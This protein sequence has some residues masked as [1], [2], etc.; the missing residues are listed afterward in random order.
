[1]YPASPVSTPSSDAPAI[2]VV[3]PTYGRPQWLPEAIESVLAQTVQD[4]EL[5]VVD[6]ASPEAVSVPA[7]PKVR[8][9][10]RE[11]NGGAAAARNTG[12]DAAHGRLLAFLDDDD[13][14]TPERLA[15]GLRGTA[16][17]PLTVCRIW[18]LGVPIASD[19]DLERHLA[20]NENRPLDGRVG[21]VILDGLPPHLGQVT[22]ERGAFLPFEPR[23]KTA[24]DIEWWLRIT[25]SVPVAT[26]PDVGYLKRR[27]ETS[28]L[29][30]QHQVRIDSNLLLL[31]E[32]ADWF[33]RHPR[34]AARRWRSQA[35]FAGRMGDRTTARDALRRSMRLDPRP[36]TL[37]ALARTYLPG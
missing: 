15:L 6:D 19:A 9:I 1:V 7:H 27:H 18:T 14:Y 22:I 25:Q 20:R 29:N 16:T 3:I 33:A 28:R 8:L 26:V 31:E 10:R 13:A 34:A 4:F 11:A 21:D 36:S 32:H 30:F 23:F 5:I 37:A 2:S 35:I 17:G 12:V 24:E